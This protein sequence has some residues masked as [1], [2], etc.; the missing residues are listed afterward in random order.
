MS[1]DEIAR[2]VFV[3]EEPVPADLAMVFADAD[4]VGM[5]RR[6]KRGVA[7]YRQEYVPRLLVTGGG[8][9]ARKDPEAK[10]MAQIS[11]DLGVPAKDLLVEDQSANTFDNVRFSLQLLKDRE[12]LDVL[13][14]ILLVSAEWHMRRVLLTMKKYFPAT[15]RLVCC[16]T[17]EGFNRDN[18][19][20]SDEG[21]RSV[22]NEAELL[23]AFQMTGAL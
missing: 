13:G 5:I 18:W 16:P 11:C 22:M 19:T 20:E 23:A 15:I 3:R 12:L 17:L 14:V 8:V 9:L 2:S 10:R 4:E 7:L 6:T 1:D 21:R